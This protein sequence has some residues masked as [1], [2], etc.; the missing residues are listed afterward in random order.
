[1]QIV[2][3]EVRTESGAIYSIEQ[4]QSM[5]LNECPCEQRRSTVQSG[6]DMNN[7]TVQ[8]LTRLPFGEAA[9]AAPPP[10]IM[11]CPSGKGSLNLLLLHGN[12]SQ[13]DLQRLQSENNIR[14]LFEAMIPSQCRRHAD[15]MQTPSPR[16]REACHGSLTAVVAKRHHTTLDQYQTIL[17]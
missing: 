1:M 10:P 15:S 8:Q 11:D 13:F 5:S 12:P 7:T 9:L 14:P 6:T 4:H 2:I 3:I 17:F 16:V